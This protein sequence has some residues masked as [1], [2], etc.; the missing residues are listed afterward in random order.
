MAKSSHAAEDGDPL[1]LWRLW[2]LDL[3]DTSHV[4]ADLVFPCACTVASAPPRSQRSQAKQRRRAAIGGRSSRDG[5]SFRR[6]AARHERHLTYAVVVA[7]LQVFLRLT[8]A[9]ATTL[10]LPMLA[11]AAGRGRAAARAGDAVLVLVNTCGVLGSALAAREFGREAMCAISGVLIVF[12]QV[13]A[14]ASGFSFSVC[15]DAQLD[16]D[17][18]EKIGCSG[19][20]RCRRSWVPR[21]RG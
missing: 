2:T 6:L 9:N 19:R 20:S 21:T 7:M 11:Q 3:L 4:H 5:G 12:C 10:L 15:A 8:R 17:S 18:N 16:M 13:R 1:D 14:Y